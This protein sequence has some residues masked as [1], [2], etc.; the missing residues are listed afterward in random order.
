M[1]ATPLLPELEDDDD[2]GHRSLTLGHHIATFMDRFPDD[3]F[4]IKAL[5]VVAALETDEH[6]RSLF[7]LPPLSA[8]EVVPFPKLPPRAKT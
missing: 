7:G 8:G 2:Y 1:T 5:A 3:P 6:L 4:S